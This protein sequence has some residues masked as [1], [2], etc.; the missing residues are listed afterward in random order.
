MASL[1]YRLFKVGKLPDDIRAEIAGESVLYETQGIRVVLHRSGRVPGARVAGG[2]SGAWGSFAVTERRIVGSRARAKLVD[3]PYDAE[4]DGPA[5]IMLDERGLHA[6][7]DLDRVHPSC[8][9]TMRLDFHQDLTAG[10]LATFPVTE[11]S[12]AVDPQKVVRL[13][14]S[15]KKLPP[16][17]PPSS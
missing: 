11:M 10:D 6:T 17:G 1:V 8:S 9:G 14:G 13:F 16:E 12:I 2:V 7:F 15:L 3:A 4:S 5:T